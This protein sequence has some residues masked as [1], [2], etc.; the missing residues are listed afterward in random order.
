MK[1]RVYDENLDLLKLTAMNTFIYDYLQNPSQAI[2]EAH[3]KAQV[4]FFPETLPE[5]AIYAQLSSPEF[6]L[7]EEIILTDDSPAEVRSYAVL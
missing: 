7:Y 3:R 5:D 6:R 4:K 1:R 2:A